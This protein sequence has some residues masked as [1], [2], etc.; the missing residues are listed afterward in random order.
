MSHS[1]ADQRLSPELFDYLKAHHPIV[2][3]TVGPDGRPSA[4]MVSWVLAVDADVIRLAIG[5]QRPSV[6]NIRANGVLALQVLGCGLAYE[7]KGAARIIKER[8]ESIRFPQAM[9]ELS[10]DSLRENMYPANFV[11]GDVPVSWPESTHGHH[12]QWNSAIAE[13]MKTTCS[14]VLP[15]NNKP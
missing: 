11:T 1:R 7:I 9:V 10:V 6:T 13:E 12:E 14:S 4:D 2:V 15:K 8:C 5:S 3:I